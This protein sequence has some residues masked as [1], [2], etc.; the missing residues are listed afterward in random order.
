ME[1]IVAKDVIKTDAQKVEAICN[2]PLPKTVRQLRY[3][4]KFIKDFAAI[5]KPLNK[6]LSGENGYIS[7]QMSK[8]IEVRLA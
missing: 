3:Y 2:F 1:Y 8:K 5:A 4:R 6:H 7:Q